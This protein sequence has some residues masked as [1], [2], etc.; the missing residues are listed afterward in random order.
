MSEAAANRVE[1]GGA[2]LMRD[3]LRYSPAAIPILSLRLVHES[4][5]IEADRER[6]VSAEL[7][8]LAAGR[9]AEALDRVPLGSGLVL[10]GFLAPR[11]NRSR[12]LLL[13]VTEFRQTEV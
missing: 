1:I 12:G 13:H 6:T 9:V 2:L 3:A 5:Q 4:V 11:S 10:R 8:A 7:S